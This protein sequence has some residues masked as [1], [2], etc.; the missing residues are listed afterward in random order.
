DLHFVACL[1]VRI[2]IGIEI[3]NANNIFKSL[4][5]HR[6]RVHAQA[7]TNCPRNS[8]H[9][10]QPADA[11][12]LPC[13]SHVP[14][15]CPNARATQGAVDLD[16]VES[17]TDRM[18]DHT[19]TAAVANGKI[20]SATHREKR[21]IFVPAKPD[22]FGKGLLISRLDPE[23]RRTAYAQSGVLPERLI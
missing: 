19:A 7:T 14:Q 17:A 4:R 11:S 2:A 13:V 1:C 9:P 5:T 12:G 23:L 18:N 8:F 22:Q 3:A 20:R 10:F 6:A 16:L 21:K 15:F